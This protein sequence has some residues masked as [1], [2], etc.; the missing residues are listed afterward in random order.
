ME[1]GDLGQNLLFESE[2]LLPHL[3]HELLLLAL[4]A[5]KG[6][7]SPLLVLRDLLAVAHPDVGR[8]GPRGGARTRCAHPTLERA[9]QI[10][11]ERTDGVLG[12]LAC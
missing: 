9:R 6:R 4:H 12:R 5:Q 8:H 11:C 1:V 7:E 3:P 10:G 2:H